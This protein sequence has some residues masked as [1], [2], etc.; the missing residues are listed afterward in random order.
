MPGA[1][2]GAVFYWSCKE[3]L[4]YRFSVA[5]EQNYLEEFTVKQLPFPK[6]IFKIIE[7]KRSPEAMNIR[8]AQE[9]LSLIKNSGKLADILRFEVAIGQKYAFP[10]IC[11]VFALIGTV[12]GAKYG[13][14]NRARSFG[15]CVA[16]VFAYYCLGFACGSLGITAVISPGLAAW[17]PNAIAL[18]MGGYL[19]VKL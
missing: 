19:L 1:A 11:I 6:T 18:I 8:Q 7:Q 3:E 16:V 13:Q 10:F 9:Y 14:L 4:N 5:A 2:I 12:L 17:L 15:L